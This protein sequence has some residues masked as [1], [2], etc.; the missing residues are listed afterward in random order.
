MPITEVLAGIGAAASPII[1]SIG[2]A[3]LQRKWALQDWNRVNAYNHPKEQV[4]RNSEAGLPLAAMFSQ[5]GSTSSAPSQTSVDPTLGTAQGLEKF[6][7][8]RMQRKQVELIDQQIREQGA[9]A[10]IIEG[11]RNWLV[12]SGTIL[13]ISTDDPASE[14]GKFNSMW[15]SNQFKS[16][17]IN[18]RQ[19]EAQA[20]SAEIVAELQ[21]ATTQGQIN[22]ILQTIGLSKEN[23]RG[24]KIANDINDILTSKI[25]DGKW[26]LVQSMIYK[27]IF[28]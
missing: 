25:G 22:H 18:Q 21:R 27:L 28:K 12:K 20:K 26:D 6:F 17:D 14:G 11:E 10:D 2:S 24:Q 1:G 9:K 15:K 19:K 7:T 3:A 5:G 23:Q 8:N 13:P 16:L 4:K